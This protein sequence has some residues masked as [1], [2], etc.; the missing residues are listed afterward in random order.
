IGDVM[1]ATSNA[2]LPETSSQ[3]HTVAKEELSS[4]NL[5]AALGPGEAK[6]IRL[7]FNVT[8]SGRIAGFG[9]YSAGQISDFTTPRARKLPVQDKSDSFALISYSLA[10]LHAK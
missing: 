9:V 7:T 1:V 4:R 5:Q 3:W 6:Y 2:R 8:K 10:D